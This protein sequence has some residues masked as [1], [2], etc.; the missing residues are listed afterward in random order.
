MTLG[1]WIILLVSVVG[2]TL[3]LGWCLWKVLGTPE[4]SDKVHGF[5]FE[6]PDECRAREERERRA[7]RKQ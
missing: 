4:E 6:T 1:G 7:R 5:E 3:W 2:V